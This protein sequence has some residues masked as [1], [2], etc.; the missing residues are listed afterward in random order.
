MSKLGEQIIETEHKLNLANN[1]LVS[2]ESK[3]EQQLQRIEFLRA[4][5]SELQQRKE[6]ARQKIEKLQEQ[7]SLFTANLTQYKSELTNCENMLEEK[8][9]SVEQIQKTI[10]EINSDCASLEADLEDEKSGIIDIV[11]RTAQ[12]HNE[13]QSISVYRNNLSNQKDR[14]AGRAQT[15]KSELEK[16]LTEKAQHK[17]RLDDIEKVLDELQQNLESKRKES[18][19]ID[20][21]LAA[22]NK[23]LK[24]RG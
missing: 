21:L 17:T 6:S 11:R 24:C 9:S 18:D 2:A 22:D 15:A 5:V 3:I 19:G 12:L 23:R 7:K 13:I 20:S 10:Q 8:G 14:L 16:L 1:A 4:R